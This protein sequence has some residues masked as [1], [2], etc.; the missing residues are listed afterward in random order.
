MMPPRAVLTMNAVGFMCASR[1]AL[2]RPIVSG[3]FGQWMVM[4]SACA[5]AL[6][7]LATGS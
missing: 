1:A 3:V 5:T 6:S 4:K 2:K 7:R